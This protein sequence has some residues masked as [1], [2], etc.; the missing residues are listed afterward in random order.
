MP[1]SG[2][3]HRGEFLIQLE[4][5]IVGNMLLLGSGDGIVVLLDGH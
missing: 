4:G 5:I 3:I 1:Y 2:P